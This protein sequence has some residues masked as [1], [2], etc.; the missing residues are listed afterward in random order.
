MGHRSAPVQAARVIGGGQGMG[1]E[2]NIGCLRSS[3]L[4]APVGRLLAIL[5]AAA[6]LLTVLTGNS[7]AMHVGMTAGAPDAAVSGDLLSDAAAATSGVVD[8]RGDVPGQAVAVLQVGHDVQH[9]MHLI[10]VCLAVL[11]AA[12]VLLWLVSRARALT[13]GYSAVTAQPCSVPRA[14]AG[15]WSPPPPSPPRSSPAIR[16]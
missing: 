9:L 10:G 6:F 11:A 4:T 8:V 1:P 14:G 2:M 12:A 3:R 5:V 13:G 7:F 15:A 16:T